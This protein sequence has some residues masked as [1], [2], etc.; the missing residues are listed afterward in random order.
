MDYR[1]LA[2]S[3]DLYGNLILTLDPNQ[4]TSAFVRWALASTTSS[5]ARNGCHPPKLYKIEFG[6]KNSSTNSSETELLDYRKV[7]L[8]QAISR[9]AK[10]I[11]H[12]VVG[13]YT[14]ITTDKITKNTVFVVGIPLAVNHQTIHPDEFSE[15]EKVLRLSMGNITAN[16]GSQTE[17]SLSEV[18]NERLKAIKEISESRRL[19]TLGLS[20]WAASAHNLATATLQY[21]ILSKPLDVEILVP[22][23]ETNRMNHDALLIMY[24]YSRV[25]SILRRFDEHVKTGEYPNLPCLPDISFTTIYTKEEELQLLQTVMEWPRILDIVINFTQLEIN[26]GIVTKFL[27]ALTKAFNS[28]YYEVVVLVPTNAPHN[29]P[30]MMARIYLLKSV[31]SVIENCLDVL[32]IN[33]ADTPILHEN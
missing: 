30:G 32:Q 15:S 29:F 31:C 5:K 26:V 18:L 13:G 24:N 19:A 33:H 4:M 1:V 12:K 11:G 21:D 2:V 8:A 10:M 16:H 23:L 28:F 6:M 27:L 3:P 25:L 14:N 22:V 17:V 20:S 7:L 9:V